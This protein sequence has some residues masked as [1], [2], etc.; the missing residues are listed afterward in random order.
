VDAVNTIKHKH[1]HD[2]SV[3]RRGLDWRPDLL[4]SL[5]QR[6]TT[7]YSSLLQTLV[8][9]VTP[10]SHLTTGCLPS[11]C[12][13]WRQPLVT[14]DH[15]FFFLQLNP[16]SRSS[17]ATPLWRKDGFC[18]LWT[19]FAFV[20]PSLPLLLIRARHKPHRKRLLHYWFPLVAVETYCFRSRYL[21]TTVVQLHISRSLPSNRSTFHNINSFAW[22]VTWITHI[23]QMSTQHAPIPNI[24][25]N[26]Y[27]MTAFRELLYSGI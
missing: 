2:F 11:I 22:R 17:Y 13:S 25:W 6:V 9:T 7:F 1:C 10:R 16:C 3:Y 23:L 20:T 21:A 24:F 4:D 27:Y 5:I 12:S 8:S 14:H 15:R 26:I 19:G 18:L